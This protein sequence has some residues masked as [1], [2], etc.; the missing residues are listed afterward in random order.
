MRARSAWIPLAFAAITCLSAGCPR[1]SARAPIAAV[2]QPLVEP[3]AASVLVAL[4]PEMSGG[5]QREH[6]FP[7]EH[8]LLSGR[9]T[10]AA[11]TFT[12]G[13]RKIALT[14]IDG[15]GNPEAYRSWRTAAST[16]LDTPTLAYA[17]LAIAGEP[18]VRILTRYP[19]TAQ[20]HV[21][22]AGRFLVQTDSEE[23]EPEELELFLGGLPLERLKLLATE[24]P[25]KG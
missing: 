17:K 8:A 19:L 1:E 18:A 6:V 12:S 14:L 4:V 22:V 21:L 10:S 20:I 5:W 25:R 16:S 15:A 7:G 3:V 13:E 2:S 23:L 24:I 11:A 9:V